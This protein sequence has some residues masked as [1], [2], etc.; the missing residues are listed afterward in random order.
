MEINGYK[1]FNSN[2]TDNCGRKF[3]EGKTYHV[4]GKLSFDANGNGFSMCKRLE[5]SFRSI[6]DDN[7]LVASVT[8][9]G[10]IEES[11]DKYYDYNN[12][13]VVSHLCGNRCSCSHR[14]CRFQFALQRYGK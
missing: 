5:D 11:F 14:S 9:F 6:K 3:E 10:E 8:G 7:S 12:L 2:M 4:D 13:Y 1:A